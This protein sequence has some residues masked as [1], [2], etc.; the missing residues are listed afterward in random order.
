MDVEKGDRGGE[1]G[2]RR[3]GAD[4]GGEGWIEAERGR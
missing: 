2:L 3:R 1:G 4:R